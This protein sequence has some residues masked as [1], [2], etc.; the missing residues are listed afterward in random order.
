M[1]SEQPRDETGRFAPVAADSAPA[2]EVGG[3]QQ[4]V[5]AEPKYKVKVDGQET[6]VSLDEALKG[7]IRQETFR[8][9]ME[10]LKAERERL[11]GGLQPGLQVPPQGYG[12][13]DPFHG[14]RVGPA[15]VSPWMGTEQPAY[16]TTAYGQPPAPSA[17]V[18]GDDEYVDVKTFRYTAAQVAATNQRL[19]QLEEQ[20]RYQEYER[21][22]DAALA[23]MPSRIPG[24]DANAAYEAILMLPEYAQ[25]EYRQMPRAA[26]LEVAHYRLVASRKPAAAQ[27][28]QP[29]T[30]QGAQAAGAQPAFT[31]PYGADVRGSAIGTQSPLDLRSVNVNDPASMA[32]MMQKAEKMMSGR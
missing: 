32:A 18:A 13:A 16:G 21:Q 15:G 19:A 3:E 12:Q 17:P 6:E 14:G 26:A 10:D 4:Q 25:Q 30:G 20:W 7:Y 24:F 8:K 5:Q 29:Q 22:Q 9:R 28:Q 23:A 11:P 31:P 1:S 27:P 2:T